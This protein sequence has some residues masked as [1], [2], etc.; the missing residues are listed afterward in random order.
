[1]PRF[2][3][4]KNLIILFLAVL[5]IYI[6]QIASRSLQK[7]SPGQKNIP[8]VK[9]PSYIEK[10][11]ITNRVDEN[12][13]NF[14]DQL[15]IIEIM[16]KNITNAHA[17]NLAK[18]LGFTSSY[19]TFIDKKDGI[20]YIWD[21]QNYSLV[22]TPNIH[23]LKYY[24][25]SPIP[26][27][28]YMKDIVSIEKD[29][30]GFIAHVFDTKSDKIKV[31]SIVYYIKSGNDVVVETTNIEQALFL[32]LNFS[33]NISPYPVNTISP[34]KSIISVDTS[35]DGKIYG[36]EAVLFDELKI[37]EN[38][39]PLKNYGDFVNTINEANLISL[40]GKYTSLKDV[41]ISTVNNI[42]VG[43]VNLIYLY[44]QESSQY[45]HP[46]YYLEGNILFKNGTSNPVQLLL[47]A[48]K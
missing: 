29:V 31:S 18:K 44:N 13:F 7:I 35:L 9:I 33:Y 25:N 45:L 11:P 14:P 22:I 16:K 46:I 21:N 37:T 47:D 32:R 38:M 43:K 5:I 28:E 10:I 40:A 8:Q 4:K 41:D 30:T 24:F 17:E 2:L 36:M 15:P 3:N 20:K 12:N 1:M 42:E 23:S 26:Q 6:L 34:Y 48:S 19:R 27:T 39:I